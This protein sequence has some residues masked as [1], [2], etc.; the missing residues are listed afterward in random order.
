MVIL[1]MILFK[2]VMLTKVVWWGIM[3]IVSIIVLMSAG[4]G[5]WH[6]VVDFKRGFGVR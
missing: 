4:I 5:L 3:L 1:E 6:Y 2:L